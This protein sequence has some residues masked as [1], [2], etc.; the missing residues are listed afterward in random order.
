[1][2]LFVGLGVPDDVTD[3]IEAALG[4]VREAHPDL[5]WTTPASWHVTLAFIGDV[6]DADREAVEAAVGEGV[7]RAGV[8]PIELSLDAPG[9]FGHRV[10]W[11]GVRDRPSGAV[12]EVGERIQERLADAEV[13]VDRKEVRPHLTL[14][15]ARGR[16]GRL[17]RGLVEQLPEVEGTW[18]ATEAV[19][20]RSHLG[21]PV[22]YERLWG[23]PL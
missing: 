18:T 14:V 10:A 5:N 17:P 23:A 3:G 2:R 20:Y 8:G 22:R 16:G 6:D 19:L 21:R 12:A 4:E 7:E 15:R 13:P 1:M 9:H 11:L